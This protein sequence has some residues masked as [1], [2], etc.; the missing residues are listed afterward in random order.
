VNLDCDIAV[1]GGGMAG[2]SVAAHLAEFA[3]V[4][5]LEMEGQPG[6]HSTGRSA[7]LF[8]ET[9]GNDAIR[10]LT[11]ASRSF[12][13]SPP[14]N[15]CNAPLMARRARRLRYSNGTRALSR[16]AASLVLNRP[17]DAQLLAFGV[18]TRDLAPARI[19]ADVGV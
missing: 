10:A 3:N 9:Y 6:Y 5:L 12:F 4:S 8:S 1:I 18:D 7:A 2:A 15:F 17:L 14:T 13:H 16:L 19:A 11:R